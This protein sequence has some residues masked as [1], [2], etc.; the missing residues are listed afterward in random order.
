LPKLFQSK[1][2]M[3]QY[4]YLKILHGEIHL[5]GHKMLSLDGLNPQQEER[6]P[7]LMTTNRNIMYAA[8]SIKD[9]FDDLHALR[10]SSNEVKYAFY[11]HTS[12][13]MHAFV[14]NIQAL[15]KN[16]ESPSLF[17]DIKDLYQSLPDTY[18]DILHQLYKDD[19]ELHLNVTEISTLLNFNREIYSAIKSF[20]FAVKDYLLTEEEANY[21]DEL[22]GFIR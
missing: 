22:P 13:H 8:K 17:S 10:E 5:Y 14:K 6:L 20:V 12:K 9:A 1:N 16:R 4:E 15:M 7:Q 11:T 19:L 2:D 21:F 3:E 18:N